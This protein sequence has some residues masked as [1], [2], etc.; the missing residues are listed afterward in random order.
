MFYLVQGRVRR[1]N[2]SD[3]DTAVREICT[4]WSNL[5]AVPFSLFERQKSIGELLNGDFDLDS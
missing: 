4:L 3:T 1:T 5:R 2:T